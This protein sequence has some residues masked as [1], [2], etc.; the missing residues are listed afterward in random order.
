MKTVYHLSVYILASGTGKF[1][2]VF[3]KSKSVASWKLKR[4]TEEAPKLLVYLPTHA[5]NGKNISLLL[6]GSIM[7][8]N[9]EDKLLFW[10]LSLKSLPVLTH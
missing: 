1:T 6:A 5:S 4:K 10:L 2:K 8:E 7:C 3:E 9:Q